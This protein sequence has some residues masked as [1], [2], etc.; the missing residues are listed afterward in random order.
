MEI[1]TSW[2]RLKQ[3]GCA[4]AGE[5]MSE[6]YPDSLKAT[7][8]QTIV[9]FIEGAPSTLHTILRGGVY[10]YMKW[11]YHGL[12]FANYDR[13]CN[14]FL[15]F[16]SRKMPSVSTVRHSSSTNS[17]DLRQTGRRNSNP[18]AC[19]EFPL[20]QREIEPVLTPNSVAAEDTEGYDTQQ[21]LEPC[22]RLSTALTSLRGFLGLMAMAC[23][24]FSAGVTYSKFSTALL[25][26]LP[27]KWLTW[28][29]WGDGGGPRKLIAT[30]R[31][32]SSLPDRCVVVNQALLFKMPTWYP[33]IRKPDSSDR[34]NLSSWHNFSRS[35]IQHVFP[36]FSWNAFI[37]QS[38][39]TKFKS[40][41][42]RHGVTAL[43]Y[44]PRAQSDLP[45]CFHDRWTSHPRLRTH[46]SQHYRFC[47]L[48]ASRFSCRIIVGMPHVL[49]ARY[50]FQIVAM[51]V[52]SVAIKVVHLP[53]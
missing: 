27:S 9:F 34:T 1:V 8:A 30:S 40:P 41:R 31:C 49:A 52:G 43:G 29:C 18:P 33:S 50:T 35:W 15:M 12:A 11:C 25:V 53:S 5:A 42:A 22:R 16:F 6:T 3:Y 48:W 26:L 19:L 14:I 47:A 37:P 2:N 44:G 23:N 10:I 39:K 38:C 4:S 13:K 24:A 51:I 7:K 20:R 36:N 17:S 46:C 21:S 45:C 32:K 28:V